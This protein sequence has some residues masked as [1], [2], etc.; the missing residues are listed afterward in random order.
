VFPSR[1]VLFLFLVGLEIETTSIRRNARTSFFISMGGMILPF[2]IGAGMSKL[3]YKNYVLPVTPDTPFTHF[4]LF[5]CVAYSI[6]AFPVLCRILTELKLLDTTVGICVLSAG[7]GNDIVGWTLLAL[8][9]ALVNATSGL[10]A[11]YIVLVAHAWALVVIIPCKKIFYYLALKTDSLSHNEPSIIFMTVTLI[12]VFAS[13][14]FTDVIGVHAIFGGFLAGLV[15][16]RENGLAIKMMEKIEDLVGIMFLP[17]V[18]FPSALSHVCLSHSR[19]TVLHPL[20][21]LHQPGSSKHGQDL[22][23][24]HRHHRHR[25]VWQV[26]RSQR[27]SQV[28]RIRMEGIG[29]YW[30]VDELQR[31]SRY[32]SSLSH[33]LFLVLTLIR[34]L[35]ELIVLNVGLEAGILDTLVFSMF[36]LEA[37]VLTFITTPGVVWLYPPQLRRRIAKHPIGTSKTLEGDGAAPGEKKPIGPGVTTDNLGLHGA[38]AD[39]EKEEGEKWGSV[40]VILDKL[41]H[42]PGLICVSELLRRTNTISLG[43]SLP[44]NVGVESE[45]QGTS[46][47]ASPLAMINALPATSDLSRPTTSS[48][49]SHSRAPLGQTQT[50]RREGPLLH[51]LRL[52]ELTDRTSAV[53][54]SI[55][56]SS[57]LLLADPLV[58]IFK[59]IHEL[60][61]GHVRGMMKVEPVE[62]WA[63]VVEETVEEIREEV[64]EDARELVV[65]CWLG[66]AP[67]SSGTG[68]D[69][70]A[71][72]QPAHAATAVP[73][74]FDF[75]FNRSQ[76]PP[77]L[78]S[79]STNAVQQLVPASRETTTHAHFVRSL[80]AKSSADVALYVDNTSHT[81]AS[82]STSVGMG[83]HITILFPF[84]GGPDDRTALDMVVQLCRNTGVRGVV[85]RITKGER[86]SEESG[87]GVEKPAP[88]YVPGTVSSAFE[89]TLGVGATISGVGNTVSSFPRP[90]FT[91]KLI[92]WNRS[93]HS[94]I[95][96][97]PRTQPPPVS[98]LGQQTRCPGRSTRPIR[99]LNSRLPTSNS[100]TSV[101]P[102][103]SRPSTPSPAPST[104]KRLQTA[105]DAC[106]L[107]SVGREGWLWRAI[108]LNWL[109]SLRVADTILAESSGRR[110]GTLQAHLLS[111]V[112]KPICSSFKLDTDLLPLASKC[113]QVEN[114]LYP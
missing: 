77:L 47:E 73:N 36:V 38:A 53:M 15:V 11:L 13:A 65:A 64:G 82:S 55:W 20:G 6:T 90:T 27:R 71:G 60:R 97:T 112:L 32:H 22:G 30:G 39:E 72:E 44:G 46:K 4:M 81:D 40:T 25:L 18:S 89:G 94:R 57:S 31:V 80:F 52:M 59:T 98:N 2:S 95:Q 48:K 41:E 50:I 75:F 23:I 85:V 114:S 108:I 104:L 78:H 70:Q 105:Q 42:L 29:R 66:D 7:V 3:I 8:S 12:F 43:R 103:L 79:K 54:K 76:P 16:P 26:R 109:L 84:F 61:G 74:P 100:Q 67:P 1:L 24:H 49:D 101:R 63:N 21:S 51:A 62:E 96:S 56:D 68:K 19:T 91:M 88:S 110:L 10:T 5:T 37:L 28:L 83:G 33:S 107:S 111:V 9:V 92:P 102:L 86:G 34:R 93:Q 17:L 106:L 35:V 87:D 58:N 45:S 113:N 14:F 69:E 99:H